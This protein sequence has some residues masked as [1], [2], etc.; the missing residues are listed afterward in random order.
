MLS[1]FQCVLIRMCLAMLPSQQV[2]QFYKDKVVSL[3]ANKPQQE[4]AKQID[5]SLA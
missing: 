2:L 4:V 1:S 5:L 3:D